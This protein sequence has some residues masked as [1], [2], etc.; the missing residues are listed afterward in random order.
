[1]LFHSLLEQ[2]L[3]KQEL[4]RENIVALPGYVLRK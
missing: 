1:M 3:A 4:I 2:Y